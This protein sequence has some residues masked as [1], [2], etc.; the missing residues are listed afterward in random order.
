LRRRVAIPEDFDGMRGH[1]SSTDQ[2]EIIRWQIEPLDRGR[3]GLDERIA[4]ALPG[5]SRRLRAAAARLPAGSKRRRAALTRAVRVGY[6]A[7]NRDDFEAMQAALHDDVEF[8]P[9]MRGR[10]GLGFDPVYRGPDGVTRFVREWKSGF[11]RF[12]YEPREIADAGGDRFA[13]RL[14]MIGTLRGADTEVHD[15]YGTVVTFKDGQVIRQENFQDWH[16]ALD[17]L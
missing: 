12:R 14:D 9:P 15:E 6:A 5:L 1:P 13:V 3:R 8:V 7:T 4:L 11:S 17:A 16:S 2:R 10:G